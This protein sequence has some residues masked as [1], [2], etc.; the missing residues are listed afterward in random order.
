[1]TRLPEGTVTFLLTDVEGST[2]LWEEEPAAMQTALARHDALLAGVIRQHGG[3]VIK[4]RGEGDSLFAVFSRA[5]DAVAAASELQQALARESWP[6]TVPLRVRVALNT[7]EAQLREGDYY[8]PAVNR[9]ARLRAAA[10]G[11]QVL[12]FQA[13]AELV[14]AGL[15]QGA[16]LRD[17]GLHRLRDLQ[18]A[19]RVHQLVVPGLPPDFPPLRSLDS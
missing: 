14:R 11:G 5:T 16:T 18:H 10:H 9:S 8:G 17:L 15:P 12:L 19:E 13:V 7:D 4:S 6:T 1:M 3:F 2:R